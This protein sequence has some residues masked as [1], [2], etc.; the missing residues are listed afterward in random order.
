MHS[1]FPCRSC[2]LSLNFSEIIKTHAVHIQNVSKHLKDLCPTYGY[3]RYLD[4][5]RMLY[6]VL[7]SLANGYI[8]KNTSVC[9]LL[10]TYPWKPGEEFMNLAGTVGTTLNQDFL[11]SSSEQSCQRTDRYRSWA[12]KNW[13]LLDLNPLCIHSYRPAVNHHEGLAAVVEV[14]VGH[15]FCYSRNEVTIVLSCVFRGP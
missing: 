7:C 1:C 10:L 3:V 8:L 13:D 6:T 12:S 4:F 5:H 9:V 11:N 2:S 15:R 14:A